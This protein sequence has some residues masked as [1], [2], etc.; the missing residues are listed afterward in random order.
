L[1]EYRPVE[2]YF[3][4][5]HLKVSGNTFHKLEFGTWVDNNSLFDQV[6][7]LEFVNN[8]CLDMQDLANLRNPPQTPEAAGLWADGSDSQ[9]IQ[10]LIV[11]GNRF[12][13]ELNNSGHKYGIVH[14]S[15]CDNVVLGAENIC[16][17]HQ[18]AEHRAA[19]IVALALS[20][21]LAR[22]RPSSA[23]RLPQALKSNADG[24]TETMRARCASGPQRYQRRLSA[25]LCMALHVPLT[26]LLSGPHVGAR[27]NGEACRGRS[28]PSSCFW[29]ADSWGPSSVLGNRPAC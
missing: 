15:Y 10:D 24:R 7:N 5:A 23:G 22:A 8:T 11:T 17:Q 28:K 2:S 19:V 25:P 12:V 9:H 21:L 18:G 3:F 16:L 14:N 6:K 4:T 13:N 29:G 1:A 20:F 27:R 26:V